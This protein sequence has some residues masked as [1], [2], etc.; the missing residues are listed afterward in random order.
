MWYTQLREVPNAIWVCEA[1][2]YLGYT[3][4]LEDSRTK[5]ALNVF[6]QN[7]LES[8]ELRL[9]TKKLLQRIKENC[10]L[11]LGSN[12]TYMPVVYVSLRKLGINQFFD[13][14]L[15]SDESGWRKPHKRIF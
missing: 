10:K 1:L 2:N 8:L 4:N 13:V 6:F 14:V 11:G 12:F 7:Y 3:V 9:Y 15:V 5:V